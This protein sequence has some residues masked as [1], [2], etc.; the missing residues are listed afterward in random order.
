MHHG[1]IFYNYF[2]RPALFQKLLKGRT[3][4]VTSWTEEELARAEELVASK[5]GTEEWNL[6]L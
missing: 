6:V 3:Y 1:R 2:H 4:I 5:Y